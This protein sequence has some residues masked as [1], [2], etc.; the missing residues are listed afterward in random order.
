MHY[1]YIMRSLSDPDKLYYGSTSDLKARF[2]VHNAGGN[3]STKPFGPDRPLP[4]K[5]NRR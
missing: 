5:G 4:G 3:V 2:S 1:A